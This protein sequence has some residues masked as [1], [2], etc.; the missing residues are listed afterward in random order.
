LTF[1]GWNERGLPASSAAVRA[2]TDRARAALGEW[3]G[4]APEPLPAEAAE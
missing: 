4:E 2:M 1:I 3:L